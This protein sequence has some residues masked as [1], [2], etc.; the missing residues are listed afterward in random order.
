MIYYFQQAHSQFY[1]I[2]KIFLIIDF[3]KF[4]NRNKI[5]NKI[6]I[7]NKI[8]DFIENKLNSYLPLRKF[9]IKSITQK[10]TTP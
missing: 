2:L 4:I 7:E 9:F 10:G 6:V 3:H 8:V 1:D 5:P